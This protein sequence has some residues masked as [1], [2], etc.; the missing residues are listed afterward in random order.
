MRGAGGPQRP[1]ARSPED[2][3]NA[4]MSHA[5]L[6]RTFDEWARTGRAD[7]LEQ[8]H[9][10]VVR[11]VVERMAIRPG[12]QMLDLGCGTGWATRQLA[13]AA[14]GASA[15]GVDVSPAMIARAEELHSYTIRAR[16]EVAAFE[17]LAFGDAKFDR[18]FSMEALYYAAD[19]ER[20]LGELW[21]VLKP[22][23]TADVVI[24][25]FR[26][27]A[28]TAR[29]SHFGEAA[30]FAMH[31]LGEDEWRAAFARAGFEPVELRRVI[32]SRG[33]GDPASF[34]P[35]AHF[36]SWEERLRAH[37]AGSLWIHATKPA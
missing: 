11:Q 31:F 14:P 30:G 1:G 5:A 9:G 22:G 7:G 34:A 35:S 2:P 15:V 19:L 26:E 33:P 18:A 4:S 37:A 36:A 24:D 32:D 20:A 29:W 6:A 17:A 10:D 3:V 28:P 27:N 21:R 13:K 12:Q 23:G 8:G 25:F 16:Y